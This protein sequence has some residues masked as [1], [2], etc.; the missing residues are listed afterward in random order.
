MSNWRP[1]FNVKRIALLAIFVSLA[2]V[3]RILFQFIPNV[4]P[5]TVIILIITLT[6]HTLDGLIVAVL[7]IILSNTLLGMGPW[8]LAQ[9]VSYALLIAFTGVFIKRFYIPSNKYNRIFFAF[10]AF[11]I[12]LLYG[13]IISVISVKMYGINHFWAYYIRGLPFDLAHAIGN[14]IFYLLLEPVLSP[15]IK[16]Y[17]PKNV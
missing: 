13:F 4:Q 14:F 17:Y 12:G 16:K 1:Q 9:V 6:T 8:T 10:Y 15:L 2:Y 7:S 5:V 3:G 11:L